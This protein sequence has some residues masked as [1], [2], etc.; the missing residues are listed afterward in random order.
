MEAHFIKCIEQ[1]MRKLASESIINKWWD[2]FL[3]GIKSPE[4]MRLVL[5]EDFK[6]EGRALSFH[7]S[8][9]YIKMSQLWFVI[10]K[11]AIPGKTFL[12][13]QL[14]NSDAFVQYHAKGLKMDAGRDVKTSSGY[15]MDLSKTGMY[16]EIYDAIQYQMSKTEKE[17]GGSFVFPPA[18]PEEKTISKDKLGETGDFFSEI[19]ED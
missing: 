13:D 18:T 16:D 5:R 2:C 3:F 14:K 10:H 9:V 15:E 19:I 17:A 12:I 8:Q 1:Q 6:L 11:E 4:N 7:F